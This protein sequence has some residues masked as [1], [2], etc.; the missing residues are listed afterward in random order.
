MILWSPS[1]A[2]SSL[3]DKSSSIWIN[4]QRF[5]DVGGQRLGGFVGGVWA[6]KGKQALAWGW[7]GGWRRWSYTSSQHTKEELWTEMG[8]ISGHSGPVKGL[9]W[10][11]NGNYL[12]SVGYLIRPVRFPWSFSLTSIF[13]LDQTTRLHGATLSPTMDPV[14]HELGRPQVHGYDLL[15]VVFIDPLR[16]VSVADEKV[17]RVF[18]APSNFVKLFEALG[19]SK[20]A[21]EEV[22]HSALAQEHL[23]IYV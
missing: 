17:A 6:Q 20:F 12:I 9:D 4:R 14:W 5:G 22:C 1:D 16:F 18:E 2:G 21:E 19:I 15:D 10:S 7:G 11:P 3:Q 13:S 23:L 8:A